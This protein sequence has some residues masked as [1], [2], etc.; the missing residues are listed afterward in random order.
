MTPAELV[1]L[2]KERTGRRPAKALRQLATF[3]DEVRPG[4]LVALPVE[5]GATLLLGEVTG[6][7]AH[8]GREDAPLPHRRPVRWSGVVPR[9][10][11]RPPAGLQDPRALFR[12]VLD[13]EVV[14]SRART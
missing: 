5:Q 9:A 6:D 10:A 11:A 4:D 3:L 1:V 7:Y 12:V 14:A 13:P 2:A 8:A